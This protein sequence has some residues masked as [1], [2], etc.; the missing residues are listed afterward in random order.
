MAKENFHFPTDNSIND[1]QYSDNTTT[2][3]TSSTQINLIELQSLKY[4]INQRFTFV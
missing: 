2:Y 4:F 1:K 3:M